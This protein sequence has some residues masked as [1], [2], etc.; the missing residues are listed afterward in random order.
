MTKSFVLLFNRRVTIDINKVRNNLRID[1]CNN[2][3]AVIIF[4]NTNRIVVTRMAIVI[5][6]T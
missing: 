1:I 4:D 2:N 5:G 3:E 6:V